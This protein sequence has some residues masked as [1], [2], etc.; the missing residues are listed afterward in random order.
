M[1]LKREANFCFKCFPD[2][3]YPSCLPQSDAKITQIADTRWLPIEWPPLDVAVLRVMMAALREGF[4]RGKPCLVLAICW[5]SPVRSFLYYATSHLKTVFSGDED[6]SAYFESFKVSILH[7]S[8]PGTIYAQRSE[9]EGVTYRMA[10]AMEEYFNKMEQNGAL[11]PSPLPSL[12]PGALLAL[13]QTH[14]GVNW[15]RVKL[16]SLNLP[17]IS[18]A[19]IDRGGTCVVPRDAIFPLPLHLR[20]SKPLAI[21]CHLFCLQPAEFVDGASNRMED[22]LKAADSIVLRRRGAGC[23]LGQGQVSFPCD[24]TLIHATVPGPFEPQVD[25]DESLIQLLRLTDFGDD[26]T[27]HPG[28]DELAAGGEQED[29]LDKTQEESIDEDSEFSHVEP[30]KQN[31]EFKWL[32]PELPSERTFGVRGT[33]VDPAGQVDPLY[34]CTASFTSLTMATTTPFVPGIFPAG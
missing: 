11:E 29:D 12:R 30:M 14:R 22:L 5:R 24:L 31:L 19:L 3:W 21:R 25:M 13:R 28:S 27:E 20:S 32:A 26:G 10:V 7:H 1:I 6:S 17:Q 4:I 8:G 16:I 33:Y 15:H 23:L 18:V 2:L 34:T 9:E